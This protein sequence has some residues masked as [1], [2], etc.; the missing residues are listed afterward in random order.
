M[1]VHIDVVQNKIVEIENYDEYLKGEY[2]EVN[3]LRSAG[4]RS[5]WIQFEWGETLKVASKR[6]STVVESGSEPEMVQT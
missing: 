1:H 5:W 3:L 2:F 4:G 6:F